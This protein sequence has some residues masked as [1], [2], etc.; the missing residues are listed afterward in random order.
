MVESG[1]VTRVGGRYAALPLDTDHLQNRQEK[2][3]RPLGIPHQGN[4]EMP[5]SGL[6]AHDEHDDEHDDGQA[7]SIGDGEAANHGRGET[8]Y[9]DDADEM[10]GDGAVYSASLA[11]SDRHVEQRMISRRDKFIS[12]GRPER[13]RQR[14]SATVSNIPDDQCRQHHQCSHCN[15]CNRSHRDDTKVAMEEG[16]CENQR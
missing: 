2:A 8:D 1:E 16:A 15:H 10:E 3:H 5:H 14:A 13:E 4:G 6:P 11:L 7:K 9:R 12:H